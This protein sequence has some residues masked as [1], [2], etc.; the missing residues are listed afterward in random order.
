MAIAAV[1]ALAAVALP[2]LIGPRSGVSG[3]GGDNAATPSPTPEPTPT[4]VPL[5]HTQNWNLTFDY[6]AAWTLTD[7]DPAAS[8]LDSFSP[9]LG[10]PVAMGFIGTGSAQQECS[11]KGTASRMSTCTTTW[12]LPDG[13]IVLRFGVSP[14]LAISTD[15]AYI[16]TSR[17][18]IAGSDIPGAEALTID[19]IPARFAKN[20]SD[21]V[22]YS[23]EKVPGATEVLW[24]GLPRP[25]PRQGAYTIVAAINGPN[26]AELEAQA[27]ALVE[28][29]H[30]VPEPTMLPTDP[31]ALAQA[32]QP[33][34][35][36]YFDTMATYADDEHNHSYDCF[37]RTVGAS[38][39]ANIIQS[40]N[41][42]PMTKP[43]P[44]TCTTV[45]MEPNAMQ[46]WTVVLKQTWLAGP[47]YPA[48]ELDVHSYTMTDGMSLGTSFGPITT[49]YPHQ[50][51]SKYKG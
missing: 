43:L 11:Q 21:V 7:R 27:K 9:T 17:E 30:F 5:A 19:G 22:P 41:A 47:D 13:T 28:S 46:G 15:P 32:R 42:N 2:W 25:L 10:S 6:P 50:G 23:A 20:D 49:V 48:G 39:Q 37:P 8:S 3:G 4:T 26:E 31:A 35:L 33:A 44:V 24:W 45:S 34:L 16:W 38:R 18:A 40:L 29:I 51:K 1:L 12:S 14:V 36:K